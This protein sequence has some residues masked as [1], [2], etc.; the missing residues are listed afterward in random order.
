MVIKVSSGSFREGVLVAS[1]M[2][3]KKVY[4]NE[5]YLKKN[6]CFNLINQQL[7]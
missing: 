3:K 1:P 7:L 2:H 4:S 6:I 5:V